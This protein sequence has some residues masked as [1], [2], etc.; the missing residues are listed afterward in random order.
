MGGVDDAP[1][2]TSS[3]TPI[4]ATPTATTSEPATSSGP[5]ADTCPAGEYTLRSFKVSGAGGSLGEGTGG[6]VSVEFDNG[7]YE[8]DFDADDPITLTAGGGSGQLILDGEI[9][10]TYTGSGDSMTFKLGTSN[11]T[12]RLK[13]EGTSRTI[14][15]SEAAKVIGLNGKGS[16]TCSGDNLTLKVAKA[17]FELVADND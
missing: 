17:T 12:A 15:M 5:T 4:D 11:G 10:G 14:K 1:A 16:A 2:V 9:K 3:A 8:V 6:D 13:G 7:R